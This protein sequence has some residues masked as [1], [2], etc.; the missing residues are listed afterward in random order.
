MIKYRNSNITTTLTRTD[1][2]KKLGYNSLIGFKKEHSSCNV[3]SPSS[4]IAKQLRG[5]KMLKEN[6]N[7]EPMVKEKKGG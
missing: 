3:L 6:V 7:M 4:K 5:S 1:S 2:K